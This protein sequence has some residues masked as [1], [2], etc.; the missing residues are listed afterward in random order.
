MFRF[1]NVY[2]FVLNWICLLILIGSAIYLVFNWG[3]IPDRIPCHYN[4]MGEIDRWGNKV[5]LLILPAISWMTYIGLS[6]IERFPSV[7]NTGVKVTAEN[8][9]RIYPIILNMIVTLKLVTTSIFVFLSINSALAKPLPI[10]FTPTFLVLTFG[11]LFFF[12]VLL[13]RNR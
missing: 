2:T 1:R 8:R 10:W 11:T 7:W 5:E 4:A 13:F 12:M 6:V 9:E 3:S